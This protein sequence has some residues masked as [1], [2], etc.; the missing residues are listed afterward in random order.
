MLYSVH[1]VLIIFWEPMMT[2]SNGNI[3]RVTSH[4][5]G[6]SSVTGEFPAQRP[7]TQSFDVLFDLRLNQ[8]LSKQWKRQWF[9]TPS[10]SLWRHCNAPHMWIS[11]ITVITHRFLKLYALQVANLN[12]DI[13]LKINLGNC[14]VNA[15]N[16]SQV[17]WH[18]FQ[19]RRENNHYR[20]V[21]LLLQFL[22]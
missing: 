15:E 3:F 21:I 7:V 18:F 12:S 6:N 1:K 4:L 20:I 14:F 10:L 16:T 19:C 17:S 22:K 11:C 9:E 5:P 2:S 13:W 8:L